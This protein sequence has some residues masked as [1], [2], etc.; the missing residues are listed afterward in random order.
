L[1]DDVQI[2]LLFFLQPLALPV[3]AVFGQEFVGLLLVRWEPT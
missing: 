1:P 3:G 2:P